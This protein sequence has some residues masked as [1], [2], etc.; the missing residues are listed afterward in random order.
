MLPRRVDVSLIENI[1]AWLPG[2]V[3]SIGAI[4]VAIVLHRKQRSASKKSLAYEVTERSLVS[5]GAEA[6]GRVAITYEGQRVERVHLVEV[7]LSNDGKVPINAGD[8]EQPLTIGLGERAEVMTL[9]SPE[10]NQQGL[11]P[12]ISA[13]DS[14]L[15]LEPLLLNPGDSVLLKA[16]VGGFRGPVSVEA[17]IV[18]VSRLTDSRE[19]LERR[20]RWLRRAST[21]GTTAA[22]SLVASVGAGTAA[23]EALSYPERDATSVSLRSGDVLCGKVLGASDRQVTVQL[24][25]TG[26]LQTVPLSEVSTIRDRD[27]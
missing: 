22:L 27:C 17:R 7:R 19:V 25:D 13:A 26:R 18:G 3:V 14:R 5:I 2:V 8:F 10:S 21:T 12:A 1:P 9:E 23:F 24:K 15:H 20:Q 11:K 16:L 4:A 6:Q